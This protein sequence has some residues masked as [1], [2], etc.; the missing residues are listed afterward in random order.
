MSASIRKQQRQLG[1]LWQIPVSF[2]RQEQGKVLE[3]AHDLELTPAMAVVTEGSECFVGRPP[4][5]RRFRRGG[6]GLKND[7]Y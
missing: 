1:E 3:S 6:L 5:L 7:G 2:F 4:N